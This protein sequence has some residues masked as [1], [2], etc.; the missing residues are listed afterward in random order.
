MK[1]LRLSYVRIMVIAVVLCVAGKMISPQFS[2]ASNREA[3][4]CGLVDGLGAMRTQIDLYRVQ[5]KNALPPADSFE[6]FETALTTTVG[7]HG[8]YIE[9]IPKNPFSGLK[10]VRF[11]GEPAGAGEAGWRLDTKTGVF[12]ADND[13]ACAAL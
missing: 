13:A 5:H 1:K 7:Q 4:I 6:I 9:Q 3:R 11:D 10:T 8:P 12:Q 2:E